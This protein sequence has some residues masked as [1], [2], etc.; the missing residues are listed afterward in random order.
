MTWITGVDTINGRLEIRVVVW[1]QAKVCER[2]LS[3]AYAV[4]R[5]SV[6]H[7]TTSA[8]GAVL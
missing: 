6:T 2:G 1:L 8:C 3:T 7:C 5:L 4:R